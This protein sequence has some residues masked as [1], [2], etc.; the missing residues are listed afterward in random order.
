VDD[1]P[2]LVVVVDVAQDPEQHQ[3]HRP[4]QV[5]G[6]GAQVQDLSGS[7]RSASM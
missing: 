6:A 3:G 5:K 4:G 7:R 1:R 2:G